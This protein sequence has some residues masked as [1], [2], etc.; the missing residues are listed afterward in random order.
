MAIDYSTYEFLKVEVEDGVATVTMNRP[1]VLNAINPVA[2]HELHNCI[3]PDLAKDDDVKAVIITGAGR[4]FC[5]GADVKGWAAD[6][7]PPNAIRERERLRRSRLLTSIQDVEKPIIAAVNGVA[8][9]FGC[10][11]TLVCD[12]RIASENARFGEFFIKR[13]LVPDMAGMYYLPRI[14]GV[15][16]AKELMF[17]GDLIDAAEAERIG[18]ANKVV[19]AAEFE[20]EVKEF[21]RKLASLAPKAM[22]MT[23]IGIDRALEMGVG[24][25][26]EF[27]RL[28]Q[29]ICRVSEDFAE[30]TRAFVEKREPQFKGR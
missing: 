5:A 1:E 11:L 4:G 30:S 29:S 10:N 22:A 25:A 21:A 14:V 7:E 20:A 23:K 18:L 26:R 3:F 28:S 2:S 12:I 17:T 13:G 24:S 8:V 27:E 16:K 6:K 9:G 19:P 15:G